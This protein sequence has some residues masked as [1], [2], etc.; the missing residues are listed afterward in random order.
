M[1]LILTL[2]WVTP[3][4][5][6]RLSFEDKRNIELWVCFLD[7]AVDILFLADSLMNFFIPIPL[8]YDTTFIFDRKKVA[9]R[10]MKSKFIFDI[11]ACNPVAIFKYTSK[12]HEGFSD[13]MNTI[14]FNYKYVP[15]VYVIFLGF[16]LIRLYGYETYYFKL[17][18]RLGNGLILTKIIMTVTRLFIIL[19]LIA[20]LW[21][22][23]S[24]MDTGSA[25]NWEVVDHL[26]DEANSIKYITSLYW[27]VVTAMTIGYGDI[28]PSNS[29]ET[30]YCCSCFIVGVAAFSYA[31]SSL[32]NN[33]MELTKTQSKKEDRLMFLKVL[34]MEHSMPR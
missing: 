15:R 16:K 23:S 8:E 26:Q 7:T 22:S 33:I 19:H 25:I 28:T 34:E 13:A 17:L 30:F 10:Y 20:C 18:R 11:F 6:Y 24:K 29:Y 12:Y 14:T 32:S 1:I 27:A 4:I 31:L 3:I 9:M 5:P 2:C 21:A